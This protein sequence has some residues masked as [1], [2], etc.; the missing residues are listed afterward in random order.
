MITATTGVGGTTALGATSA[1]ASRVSTDDFLKLLVTQL[2]NQNPL[3]PLTNEQF[4]AQLAQFQALD[5]MISTSNNTAAMLLGAKLSLAGGLIGRTVTAE[6]SG[7]VTITGVVERVV[8]EDGEPM[9]VIGSDR[10][11]VDAVRE[12]Y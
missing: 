12:I 9:L 10:L 4:L 7:G 6:G 2:Q 3:D 11:S 5:E 1:A 8:V